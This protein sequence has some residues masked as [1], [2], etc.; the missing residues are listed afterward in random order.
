MFLFQARA[1]SHRKAGRVRLAAAALPPCIR[2]FDA[3]GRSHLPERADF[4][5]IVALL[6]ARLAPSGAGVRHLTY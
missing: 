1:T 4:V 6:D 2:L 3:H 5:R